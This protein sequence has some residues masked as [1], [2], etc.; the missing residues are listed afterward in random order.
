[1]LLLA[2]GL[3]ALQT[4]V[5]ALGLP[6]CIILVLMCAGLVKSL[7]SERQTAP[8]TKKKQPARPRVADRPQ[9]ESVESA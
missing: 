1:M 5:I 7:R 9:P 8:A 3:V 2:G 6:F 4:A